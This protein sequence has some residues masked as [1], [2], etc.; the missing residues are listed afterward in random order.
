MRSTKLDPQAELSESIEALKDDMRRFKDDIKSL[1]SD[2]GSAGKHSLNSA[3]QH[4]QET[5]ARSAEGIGEKLKQARDCGAEKLE[6]VEETLKAHPYMTAMVALG[7][8]AAL[9]RFFRP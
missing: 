1:L 3:K 8:G 2:L 9:G 4:L 7:V 5:A 6:T